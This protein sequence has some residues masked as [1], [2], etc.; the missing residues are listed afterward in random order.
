MILQGMEIEETP[1]H[2]QSMTIKHFV[3]LVEENISEP[4]I[5]FRT[6]LFLS[7]VLQLFFSATSSDISLKRRIQKKT[8]QFF[9]ENEKEWAAIKI[10]STFRG[11]RTREEYKK[12]SRQY[13]NFLSER[14]K[15]FT[16]LITAGSLLLLLLS[17]SASPSSSS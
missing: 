9:K 7:M 1:T 10:Q 6:R 3:N 11:W 4:S 8:A 14:N 5:N 17:S 12:L 15:A 13:G 2:Q 16:E